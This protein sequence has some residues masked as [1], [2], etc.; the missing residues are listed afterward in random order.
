MVATQRASGRQEDELLRFGVKRVGVE[1][2]RRATQ[3]LAALERLVIQCEAQY[4]GIDRW[5]KRKVVPGLAAGERVGY[6]GFVHGTPVAA[7]IVRRGRRTKFCHLRVDPAYRDLAIGQTLFTFLALEARGFA[8]QVYFTLPESLWCEERDF[9]KSFG[10]HKAFKA[11]KQYRRA[12]AELFCE[13]LFED[14]WRQAIERLPALSA[15]WQLGSDSFE[16]GLVMSVQPRYAERI[17]AGQKCVEV[18][19]RFSARWTGQRV[20][21]YATRPVCGLVGEARIARVLHLP[22]EKLWEQ[23]GPVLGASRGEL[24]RHLRAARQVSAI[25][26]SDVTPYVTPMPIRELSGLVGQALSAPRSFVSFTAPS[27]WGWRA[28]TALI[29][30]LQV[31]AALSAG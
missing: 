7:A 25:E 24:D 16:V 13:A 19:R 27:G 28:A 26:L 15:R 14:V 20:V 2:A 5:F 12:D 9:F 4:P 1:D 11:P 17:L 3:A 23:Y 31:R 6:I 10:F 8:E 22:S 29:D 18:R 30:L 21:F